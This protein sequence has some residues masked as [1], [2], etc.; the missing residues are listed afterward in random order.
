MPVSGT[1]PSLAWNESDPV[2]LADPVAKV[3]PMF[4]VVC[5]ARLM[6]GDGTE[7]EVTGATTEQ[8]ITYGTVSCWSLFWRLQYTIWLDEFVDRPIEA[9]QGEISDHRD[10]HVG[11]G[12]GVATVTDCVAEPLAGD[13]PVAAR[14]MLPSPGLAPAVALTESCAVTPAPMV[15][16]AGG[17]HP[18]TAPPGVHQNEKV[19]LMLLVFWTL[20]LTDPLAPGAI[21]P[22]AETVLTSTP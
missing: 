5:A 6:L 21:A 22:G 20:K 7:Q 17:V 4:T 13:G 15:A 9:V 10:E 12:G 8:E 2:P 14:V 18:I 3:T 16:L 19:A 11:C 1:D